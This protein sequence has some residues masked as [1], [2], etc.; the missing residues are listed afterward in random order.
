MPVWRCDLAQ[1]TPFWASGFP[2]HAEKAA[3]VC[4]RIAFRSPLHMHSIFSL[5]FMPSPFRGFSSN[6]HFS[7]PLGTCN[8]SPQRDVRVL[9]H[10]LP[11]RCLNQGRQYPGFIHFFSLKLPSCSRHSSHFRP[12][13]HL[14]PLSGAGRQQAASVDSRQG[15]R[16][17]RVG[18]RLQVGGFT[19]TSVWKNRN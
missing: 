9:E 10:E 12:H 19:G 11:R 6:S 5:L 3:S 1:E 17:M 15:C 16:N 14:R 4:L 7:G 8:H 18:P 13:P 2:F